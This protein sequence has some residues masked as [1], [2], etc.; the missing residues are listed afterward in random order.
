MARRPIRSLLFTSS[1]LLL[2]V[3][4]APGHEWPFG[5]KAKTQ[6]FKGYDLYNLGLLGAKGRDPKVELPDDS[7]MKEGK[8][9][10]NIQ[11]TG[12]DEGPDELI[13]EVLLADGPAA[14]A[15]LEIGDAIVGVKGRK[16][17]DGALKPIADALRKAEAGQGTITLSVR[18]AD[19]KTTRVEI[20]IP[21]SGRDASK[22]EEGEARER[23]VTA[24]CAWLAE[25]QQPDGGFKETLS[26]SNGAVVQTAL[27]GLAWLGGGSDLTQGPHAENVAKAV[28]FI[29][30]TLPSMES[31]VPSSAGGPSWNQSNWGYAHAAIFL[32]ELNHRTPSDEVT[33]CLLDCGRTLAERQE[34]SGG[35]SHGPGGRNA[36]GYLELNIVSGLALCGIG[37]AQQA[38]LE[39]D[40]EVLDRAE[41]YLKLS[42]S[43]DG[44]VG[45]SG[46][47][48]KGGSGNIGRSA[49]AWLGF[50]N[51][52][53]GKKAWGK[54]MAGWV[55]KNA[56]AVLEGHASLM[57]HYLLA[58]VA[59]HALG[60]G[61][62]KDFWK[63]GQRDLVLARSPDGSFQPRPWHETLGM[64]SNSDVTFGE[65][66]T[67]AAWTVI[68]ACEPVKGG[69]PGLPAWFGRFADGKKK[70]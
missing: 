7:P 30:A 46:E 69:R 33:R 1:V 20:T 24:G 17:S 50:A 41:A 2:S 47:N 29:V 19:G 48:G 61:A 14:T 27:A 25:R 11:R 62:R 54:K 70:S 55:K 65:V 59:A 56:G 68:L 36:L 52:G 66:W 39:V 9:S 35:W 67:T 22:P 21:T 51:L 5:D 34:G 49:G 38:G 63:T 6:A 13:I 40:E 26:G 44:G 32:G 53:L 10:F 23:S 4:H 45:Y 58:G 3:S 18:K 12:G 8:Q 42:S 64:K 31:A 37:L 15:G 28:E 57:Q 60:G 43:G 16:F